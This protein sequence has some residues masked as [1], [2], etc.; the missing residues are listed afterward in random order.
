M[1]R[2]TMIAF[3]VGGFAVAAILPL[4]ARAQSGDALAHAEH[5]C[6]NSGIGPGSVAFDSCVSRAAWAYD[7]AEPGLAVAEAQRLADARDAC[8]SYDID[9]MTLGYRQCL[10]SER[11]RSSRYAI[12][13]VPDAYR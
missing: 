4:A 10:A 9:P 5:T 8:L 2:L 7:R 12:S 1:S 11:R 13:Y 3:A 6:A